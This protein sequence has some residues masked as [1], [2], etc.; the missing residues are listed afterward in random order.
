MD[1]TQA[2]EVDGEEMNGYMGP[3]A[4]DGFLGFGNEMADVPIEENGK[5]GVFD[6]P[7]ELLMKLPIAQVTSDT[8]IIA[9]NPPVNHDMD[10]AIHNNNVTPEPGTSGTREEVQADVIA[11]IPPAPKAGTSGTLDN[12]QIEAMETDHAPPMGTATNPDPNQ[13]ESQPIPARQPGVPKKGF[14][15]KNRNKETNPGRSVHPVNEDH[16]PTLQDRMNVL[17]E[18]ADLVKNSKGRADMTEMQVWGQYMGIKACRLPEGRI[19]DEVLVEVERVM[20]KGIHGPW[21]QEE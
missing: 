12:R 21:G 3:A 15:T 19:R 8:R 9:L 7:H 5:I 11:N 6:I 2:T 17:H 10:Q 20:N 13:D 1:A 16:E 4:I 14:K 18:I